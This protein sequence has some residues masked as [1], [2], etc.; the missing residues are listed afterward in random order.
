MRSLPSSALKSLARPSSTVG[1]AMEGS[2]SIAKL[3]VFALLRRDM[4]N[5]FA[6]ASLAQCVT[7]LVATHPFQIIYALHNLA[8][9]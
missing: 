6:G 1:G 5:P 4:F 3:D 9:R 8:I 2:A 7:H